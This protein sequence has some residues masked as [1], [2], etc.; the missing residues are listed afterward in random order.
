MGP[1]M[2]QPLPKSWETPGM[3]PRAPHKTCLQAHT[4]FSVSN[5]PGWTPFQ[6]KLVMY[7]CESW[8]IKKAKHRT[9]DAFE[10]WCW[11]RL[12][13][14]PLDCKEIKQV[15]PKG[16]QPW[17]FI[18]K[19]AAKAE[20][21]ILWPPDAKSCLTGKD[22]DGGKD[23]GQEKMVP[24]EDEMTRWHQWLNAHEFEQLLETVQDREAWCTAVYGVTESDTT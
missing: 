23:W 21:P 13:K 20:A 1:C 12:F 4:R 19:T 9:I 5:H 24:K 8:T 17:M 14:S 3:A 11:R 15:N 7:R 6:Y 22:P 18:G 16:N 2:D 10:L